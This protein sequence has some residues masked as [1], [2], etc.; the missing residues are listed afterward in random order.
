MSHSACYSAVAKNCHLESWHHVYCSTHTLHIL[1]TRKQL[2]PKRKSNTFTRFSY[3]TITIRLRNGTFWFFFCIPLH[4]NVLDLRWKICVTLVTYFSP[5]LWKEGREAKV[6]YILLHVCAITI[7][8]MPFLYQF[9][10]Y[11]RFSF[12]F[13]LLTSDFPIKK[14]FWKGQLSVC[15][16]ASCRE[17]GRRPQR[18]CSSSLQ[19][20]FVPLLCTE[21][22]KF[23]IGLRPPTTY[24]Y[25]VV[26]ITSS[27]DE[28][29]Q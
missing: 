23:P 17:S 19:G 27:G 5:S 7:Q 9:C 8:V 3:N 24:Y 16:K 2:R 29:G 18:F 15:N 6:N 12:L 21:Q 20:P 22:S 1:T 25:Y 10:I 14:G 13:L 28:W 11:N 4:P 26:C